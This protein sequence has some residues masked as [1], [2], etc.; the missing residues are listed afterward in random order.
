[1]A[2]EETKQL[3]ERKRGIAIVTGRQANSVAA[4]RHRYF[5]NEWKRIITTSSIFFHFGFEIYSTPECDEDE[6]N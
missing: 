5:L 6:V 2:A 4:T 3:K 1:M